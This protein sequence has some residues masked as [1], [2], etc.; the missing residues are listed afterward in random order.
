MNGVQQAITYEEVAAYQVDNGINTYALPSGGTATGGFVVSWNSETGFTSAGW[1]SKNIDSPAYNWTEE[2][3]ES[4]ASDG[5]LNTM[6]GEW[7]TNIDF[8]I[9]LNWVTNWMNTHG[10]VTEAK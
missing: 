9:R 3:I 7:A 6:F 1:D 4:D 10:C 5:N 8:E 2:K